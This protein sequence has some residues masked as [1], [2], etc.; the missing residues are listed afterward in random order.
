[1]PVPPGYP[2]HVI[3]RGNR[4]QQTSFCDESFIRNELFPIRKSYF[5]FSMLPILD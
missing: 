3:Q 2:H 5:L 4:R 1:M